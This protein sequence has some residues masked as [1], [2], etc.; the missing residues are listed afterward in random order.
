MKPTPKAAAEAK[1]L[2]SAL[3]DGKTPGHDS[4]VGDVDSEVEELETVAEGGRKD[5]LAP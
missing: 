2:T 1:S 4:Q 3:S 5:A